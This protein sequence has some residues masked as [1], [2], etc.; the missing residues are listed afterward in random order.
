MALIILCHNL[1]RDRSVILVSQILY[2]SWKK[3]FSGNTNSVQ[4]LHAST[5]TRQ[6]VMTQRKVHLA[7]SLCRLVSLFVRVMI[8]VQGQPRFFMSSGNAKLFH[9][10]R[11]IILLHK[12]H[13][14]YSHITVTSSI[15]T[16]TFQKKTNFILHITQCNFVTTSSIII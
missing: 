11:C 9:T 2:A 13:T 5:K 6:D 7:S 16:I 14:I 8:N 4:T 3:L 12:T 15:F 10:I 1:K